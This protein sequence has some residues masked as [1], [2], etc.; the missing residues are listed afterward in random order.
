MNG[1]VN[2]RD[3]HDSDPIYA[4]VIGGLMMILAGILTL[5]VNDNATTEGIEINE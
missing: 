4:L 1:R 3:Q 5:R 2:A